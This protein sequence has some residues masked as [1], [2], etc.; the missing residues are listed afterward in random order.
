MTKSQRHEHTYNFGTHENQKKRK[1][2]LFCVF[3]TI[4]YP[5][6]P[7]SNASNIRLHVNS[8]LLFLIDHHMGLKTRHLINIKTYKQNHIIYKKKKP[9]KYEGQRKHE[10]CSKEET[11]GHEYTWVHT[12]F[13]RK[14]EQNVQPCRSY[15]NHYHCC[16]TPHFSPHFTYSP[17]HFLFLLASF[18]PQPHT[19]LLIN[20]ER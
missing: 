9:L 12:I 6:N 15:L 14:L 2:K 8:G 7:E 16:Y 3:V 19:Y 5:S 1:E 10:K 18:L 13:H 11:I 4:T 17:Q 20:L